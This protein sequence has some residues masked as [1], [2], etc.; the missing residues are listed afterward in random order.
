MTSA[1]S[2]G[3]QPGHYLAIRLGI[4]W[5]IFEALGCDGDEGKSSVQL[6]EGTGADV[7][8]VGK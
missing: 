1:N 8:L 3:N 2:Q 6:A 4:Q 5:G 7:R